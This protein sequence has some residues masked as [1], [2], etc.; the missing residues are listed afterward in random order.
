MNPVPGLDRAGLIAVARA[1][2]AAEARWRPLV[3]HD[4]AQRWFV[5]LYAAPTFEAWLLTWTT[6]QSLE[7]HDHG[8]SSGVV[9]VI[10][11][12]LT[13]LSADL[14]AGGPLHRTKVRRGDFLSFGPAHVHDVRNSSPDPATSIHVYSPPLSAMTFYESDVTDRLIPTRSECVAR[15]P[16]EGARPNPPDCVSQLR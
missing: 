15:T 10:E 14:R 6:E 11:G 4:P 16:Q 1:I 2:V 9:T 3:R 8:G 12:E 7:L 5:R 13:E